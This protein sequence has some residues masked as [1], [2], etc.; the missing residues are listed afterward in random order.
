M[1]SNVANTKKWLPVRVCVPWAPF[2]REV[3]GS[4]V[5]WQSDPVMFAEQDGKVVYR[6]LFARPVRSNLEV[7]WNR[8]NRDAKHFRTVSPNRR[9]RKN[10]QTDAESQDPR[11][12]LQTSARG[13]FHPNASRSLLPHLLEVGANL[14]K[15]GE[16]QR[17]QRRNVS[18]VWLCIVVDK[19]HPVIDRPLLRE[20]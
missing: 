6:L 13:V 17:G 1:A 14:E 8:K 9:P 7:G 5:F 18:W 2:L 16:V 3:E 4:W 11:H 19:L 15:R 12:N 10:R 20:V